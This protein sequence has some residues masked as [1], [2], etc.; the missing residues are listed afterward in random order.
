MKNFLS[1]HFITCK[2]STYALLI[3]AQLF[4]YTRCIVIHRKCLM[5]I[6][7]LRLFE[8]TLGSLGVLLPQVIN[9]FVAH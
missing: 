5:H 1:L 4:M 7:F 2:S 6:W 3:I 8:V 9:E